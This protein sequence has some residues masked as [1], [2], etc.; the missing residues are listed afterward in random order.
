MISDLPSAL[1]TPNLRGRNEEMKEMKE[2]GA[3][4]EYCPISRSY[5]YNKDCKLILDFVGDGQ[6]LKGGEK[7]FAFSHDSSMAGV[8]SITLGSQAIET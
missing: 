2:L 3:P 5:F 6:N 8:D 4:I 7:I 1:N